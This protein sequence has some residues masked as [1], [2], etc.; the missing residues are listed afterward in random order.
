MAC[1]CTWQLAQRRLTTAGL[2]RPGFCAISIYAQV[3][4]V[5]SPNPAVIDFFFF[6]FFQGHRN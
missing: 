5:T 2:A 6:F 3:N 1:A 4:V